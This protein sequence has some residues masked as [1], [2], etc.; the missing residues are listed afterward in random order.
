MAQKLFDKATLVTIPSQYKEGKIYN[1]KPE[2]QSSAFEFERGSAATRVNEDG[3]I[4][5]A[6]VS[7]TQLWNDNNLGLALM[8]MGL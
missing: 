7:N 2:D 3:L 1:I 4:E 6:G 5:Q 8:P